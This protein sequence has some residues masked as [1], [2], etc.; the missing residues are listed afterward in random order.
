M[1]IEHEKSELFEKD[2]AE[3]ESRSVNIEMAATDVLIAIW[4]TVQNGNLDE[5]SAI[6]DTALRM[7]DALNPNWPADPDWLPE[8]LRD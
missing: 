8:D 6:A 3:L 1:T 7:R 5:R 4:K 2:A